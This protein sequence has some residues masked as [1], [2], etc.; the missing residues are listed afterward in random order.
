MVDLEK[1]LENVRRRIWQ[2]AERAGRDPADV[3]LVAVTKT[4]PVEV[5]LAACALGIRDLGENRV[6]EALEKIPRIREQ[7]PAGRSVRWHMIGHL[8]HR[9]VKDAV[10]LFD[11]IESV[12]SVPLARRLDKRAAE[13][14]KSI[15]ILLEVNVSGESSRSGFAP[16]PLDALIGAAREILN[17][18]HL[19]LEGLMAIAPIVSEPDQARPYF[20]MLSRLREELRVRFPNHAWRH[21]SMGMTDDFEVAIAEGATLVRIGRAIFGERT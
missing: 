16:A 20:R 17:L 15:P 6:E 9:K 4:W 5:V 11:M 8:Q 12:D 13:L 2:A 14:G 19:E 10:R 18:E 3:T 1:N 7:L 21:L